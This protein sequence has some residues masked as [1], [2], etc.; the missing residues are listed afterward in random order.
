MKDSVSSQRDW[1]TEPLLPMVGEVVGDCAD[2]PDPVA[3]AAL[4]EACWGGE[5]RADEV[6]EGGVEVLR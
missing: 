4:E 3:G 1:E 5:W 2:V 6:F